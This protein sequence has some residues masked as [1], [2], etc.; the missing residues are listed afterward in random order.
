MLP[1]PSTFAYSSKQSNIYKS[2]FRNFVRRSRATNLAVSLLATALLFSLALNFRLWVR[3]RAHSNAPVTP[4][5]YLQASL[6]PFTA[7]HLIIVAGHAVW[8]VSVS[9]DYPTDQALLT[10]PHSR[11]VIPLNGK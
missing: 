8:K 11:A 4:N 10:F 9:T 5:S 7:S 6:Q 3:Q 2:W 1:L